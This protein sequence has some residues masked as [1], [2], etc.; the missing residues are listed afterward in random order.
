MAYKLAVSNT[1]MVPMSFSLSD[2]GKEKKFKFSLSCERLDS[3]DWD[4]RIRNDA[5]T[6]TDEQVKQTLLD[7]TTGWQGQ[8]L[9]LD[10]DGQP[11][12]FC[13][14]ALDMMLATV[15]VLTVA[16]RSYTTEVA[17]K[18]KN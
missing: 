15:G 8:T 1:V 11:A 12:P 9:V 18:Q 7:I 5:G 2:S 6:V 10:E 13:A 17:A 3:R 16:A 14:E 4:A